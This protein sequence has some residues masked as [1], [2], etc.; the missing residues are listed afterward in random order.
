MVYH[1]LYGAM[2]M[3]STF[4]NT[5]YPFMSRVSYI[6]VCMVYYCLYGAMN[7]RSTFSNTFYSFLSRV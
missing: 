5:F 2:D 7:M 1:C 4:S 3:E 6:T